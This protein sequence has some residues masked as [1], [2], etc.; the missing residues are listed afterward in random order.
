LSAPQRIQAE[1]GQHGFWSILSS[2]SLSHH[3]TIDTYLHKFRGRTSA[4]PPSKATTEKVGRPKQGH[5]ID[6]KIF[7]I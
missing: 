6:Y 7:R 5:Q 2:K 4:P 3:T 1:P